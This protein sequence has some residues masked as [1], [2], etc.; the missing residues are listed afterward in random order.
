[1]S[2]QVALVTGGSGGIGAA[3]SRALAAAGTTVLIGYA[4]NAAR[5]ESV[6]ADC[7][8]GAEGVALDVTEPEQVDAAVARAAELGSLGVFVHAAGATSDS[9]LLRL[10]PE[11]WDRTMDVNLRGAYLTARR[12]LR[13]MLRN[14]SGRIV[15][16]SSVIGL[17]GNPG[18][19]AYAAAKAGLI[20]FTRA[21]AREVGSKG[22]TV[23]AVAPGWVDT[24]MTE[25]L[26][27]EV[28]ERHLERTPTGR[29]V[30][31]DE[32]AAAVAFLAS[33]EARSITGAVLPV[34][35]GAAI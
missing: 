23:N 2:D 35:G 30:T 28:R 20:G 5:A 32:V 18:Q 12:T 6:A 27:S 26:P 16:I 11:D 10:E 19:T 31:P 1:V 13:P 15:L 14:R 25:H 33:D 17:R 7:G 21:L 34:D 4:R 29:P 3:V 9:L 8:G 24:S 22:V